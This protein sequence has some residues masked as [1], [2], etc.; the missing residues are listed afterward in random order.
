ML[1]IWCGFRRSFYK[2]ITSFYRYPPTFPSRI[3]CLCFRSNILPFLKVKSLSFSLAYSTIDIFDSFLN[4]AR[5]VFGIINLCRSVETALKSA[6]FYLVQTKLIIILKI[7]NNTKI[8]YGTYSV[9]IAYSV[10]K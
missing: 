6:C 8:K 2:P 9:L 3:M 5:A 10:H 7:I 4:K 1:G